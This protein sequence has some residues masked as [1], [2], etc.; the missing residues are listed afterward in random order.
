MGQVRDSLATDAEH[1][2]EFKE[3]DHLIWRL[4]NNKRAKRFK[5]IKS[6]C[7]LCLLIRH[8]V[9]SAQFSGLTAKWRLYNNINSFFCYSLHNSL[10]VL[11]RKLYVRLYQKKLWTFPKWHCSF[12]CHHII[13]MY[14]FYFTEKSG[15]VERLLCLTFEVVIWSNSF[16][17]RKQGRRC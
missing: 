7:N 9:S 16:T 6:S 15:A 4:C 11:I 1:S 8:C 12:F 5:K 13:W 17:S 2:V 10:V 14:I 3:P